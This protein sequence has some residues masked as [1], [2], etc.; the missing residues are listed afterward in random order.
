MKYKYTQW[1][2]Q[3]LTMTVIKKKNKKKLD[4][5]E[6][7]TL[8][9]WL[10]NNLILVVPF[11]SYLKGACMYKH[12]K[13][14]TRPMKGVEFDYNI[15][16]QHPCTFDKRWKIAQNLY[17]SWFYYYCHILCWRTQTRRVFKKKW[18][19]LRCTGCFRKI[20]IS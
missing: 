11:W 6:T 13:S 2:N 17:K 15:L 16:F 3:I 8:K 4:C 20:I 7:S 5:I 1:D 9:I 14:N 10:L 18:Y 12:G 19:H